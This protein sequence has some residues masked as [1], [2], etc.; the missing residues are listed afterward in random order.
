MMPDKLNKKLYKIHVITSCV[1]FVLGVAICVVTTEQEGVPFL[2]YT[3]AMI[4][5]AVIVCASQRY[6]YINALK[7]Q[8]AR[9]KLDELLK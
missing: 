3:V 9:D 4:G 8:E 1:T 5:C 2:I 6:S 7:S